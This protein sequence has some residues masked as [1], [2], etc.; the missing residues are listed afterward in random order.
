[1]QAVIAT[2]GLKRPVPV[3]WSYAGRV[4]SDYVTDRDA[5]GTSGVDLSMLPSSSFRNLSPTT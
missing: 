5:D 2:A 3:G 1:L 4:I